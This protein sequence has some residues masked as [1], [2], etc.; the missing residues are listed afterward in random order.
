MIAVTTFVGTSLV[1]GPLGTAGS[2][3]TLWLASQSDVILTLAPTWGAAFKAWITP[4]LM[5]L[6][7]VNAG[8]RSTIK[9][10]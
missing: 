1:F 8:V 5:R 3:L 10:P 2:D 7:E 9:R 4:I 6:R